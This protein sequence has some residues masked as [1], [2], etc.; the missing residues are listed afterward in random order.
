MAADMPEL[1]YTTTGHLTMH[2]EWP[3][4]ALRRIKA[5]FQSVILLRRL[6]LRTLARLDDLFIGSSLEDLER[7]KE[8]RQGCICCCMSSADIDTECLLQGT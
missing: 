1:M 2:A 4:H 5:L 3:L 6:G 7:S 8:T